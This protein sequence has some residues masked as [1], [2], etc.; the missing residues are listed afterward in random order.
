MNKETITFYIQSLLYIIVSLSMCLSLISCNKDEDTTIKVV[1]E[2]VKYDEVTNT[3]TFSAYAIDGKGH[4]SPY[5]GIAVS[6]DSTFMGY[7][8]LSTTKGSDGRCYGNFDNLKYDI[9]Y[10]YRASYYADNYLYY[11][12]VRQF[13][14][15]DRG[16]NSGATDLG[17]SVKWAGCNVGAM[18][19]E[20]FGNIFAWG[21]TSTKSSYSFYNYKFTDESGNYLTKYNKSSIEGVV[22]NKMTLETEDDAAT[23]VMG[24]PWR[25]PTYDEYK[26]LI[27]SCTWES[28]VLRSVPG[29]VITGPSGKSIFLPFTNEY[30]N[31]SNYWSSSLAY[32]FYTYFYAY[33]LDIST[34]QYAL[35]KGNR[36]TGYYVRAVQK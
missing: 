10:Y 14:T 36:A 25:M 30:Q 16:I 18:Q 34:N 6:T 24:E 20:E 31:G 19:P 15:T 27:D 1:T 28:T 12:E 22:D 29:Y 11:G 4:M 17:L 9:T 3:A 21:E 8:S 35:E 33:D 2:E 32:N 13:T 5:C 7:W 26:E 23:V